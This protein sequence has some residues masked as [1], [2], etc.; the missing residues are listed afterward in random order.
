MGKLY[1]IAQAALILAL[2]TALAG[3]MSKDSGANLTLSSGEDYIGERGGGMEAQSEMFAKT[4]SGDM[5]M[6]EAAPGAAMAPEEAPSP[7]GS[8][9]GNSR[10]GMKKLLSVPDIG[11]WVAPKAFAQDHQ[12][13]DQYLI[14]TGQIDLRTDSVGES[15]RTITEIA[16]K[17]QG[18]ITGSSIQKDYEGHSSGYVTLR[19]PSDRFFATFDELLGVGE[20]TNQNT[21]SQD[22]GQEYVAQISRLNSL[23]AEQATLQKMLDEALAVQRSRGLGEAYKVM[24]DTQARLS[25]VSAQIQQVETSAKALADQIT[26]STITVNLTENPSLPISQPRPDTFRW[27]F[28]AVFN[29]S[30]RNL[31]ENLRAT[32]HS[33]IRFSVSLVWIWWI[34]IYFIL[35]RFWKPIK[36]AFG[37]G[38]DARRIAPRPPDTPGGS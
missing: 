10:V 25:D 7:S 35:R 16:K 1:R 6:S 34:V 17:H 32:S 24:L 21:Q 14:R 19:V 37:F 26:R 30:V 20:V 8:P 18:S 22:V 33:L 28:S 31:M 13:S 11:G 27:D 38:S 29:D 9:A 2:L 5:A 12:I 36:R 23:M 3:C 4:A 15:V